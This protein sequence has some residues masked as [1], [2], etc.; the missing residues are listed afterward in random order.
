MHNVLYWYN[1]I[2]HIIWYFI[3]R[4]NLCSHDVAIWY[5]LAHVFT[6]KKSYPSPDWSSWA[7]SSY[8]GVMKCTV[9]AVFVIHRKLN[10]LFRRSLA[11]QTLC[12]KRESPLVMWSRACVFVG[13]RK[14]RIKLLYSIWCSKFR[15]VLKQFNSFVSILLKIFQVASLFQSFLDTESCIN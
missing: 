13:D 11:E 9:I 1:F 6:R 5:T 2:H 15:Q 3:P 10:F 12:V 8:S 7:E 14:N 4:Y